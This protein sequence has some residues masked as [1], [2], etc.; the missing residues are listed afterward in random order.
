MDFENKPLKSAA[1]IA[2][3]KTEKIK[4][5]GYSTAESN[6]GEEK[7]ER[8]AEEVRIDKEDI[9]K[10]EAIA[11]ANGFDLSDAIAKKEE[12]IAGL[13]GMQEEESFTEKVMGKP[14]EKTWEGVEKDINAPIQKTKGEWDGES[15][16]SRPSDKFD[17]TLGKGKV[18]NRSPI[19]EKKFPLDVED[20]FK[21]K[22]EAGVENPQKTEIRTNHGEVTINKA[23]KLDEFYWKGRKVAVERTSGVVESDW[24]FKKQD[25]HFVTVEKKIDGQMATKRVPIKMFKEWNEEQFSPRV[26]E[27]IKSLDETRNL[28]DV[29]ET[30]KSEYVRILESLKKRG[31]QLTG[32]SAEIIGDDGELTEFGKMAHKKNNQILNKAERVMLKITLGKIDND[33]LMDKIRKE[34][35]K[36]MIG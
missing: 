23:D 29:E 36:S 9:K 4:P 20:I 25:D 18:E 27:S 12:K 16:S 34:A 6:L 30:V 22:P 33:S 8:I 14:Q 19:I 13:G 26:T 24:S 31:I 2:M 35:L 3:E 32:K 10:I 11:I 5:E 17:R 15:V 21:K 1:E 28:E 7:S